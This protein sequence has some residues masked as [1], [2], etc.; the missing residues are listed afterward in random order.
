MFN[1]LVILGAVL[2]ALITSDG[3]RE[4]FTTEQGSTGSIDSPQLWVKVTPEEGWKF[5]TAYPTKVKMKTRGYELVETAVTKEEESTVHAIRATVKQNGDNT[6]E[7]VKMQAKFS[8]CNETVCIIEKT[9]IE[10]AITVQP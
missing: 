2:A 6:E 3:V 7:V 1:K 9:E 10:L 4:H 5:N 8:I